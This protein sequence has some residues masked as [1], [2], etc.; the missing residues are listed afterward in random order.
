MAKPT[1]LWTLSRESGTK[2]YLNKYQPYSA[3]NIGFSSQRS[4]ANLEGAGLIYN[5]QSQIYSEMKN[6]V[7]NSGAFTISFWATFDNL[8]SSEETVL[9]V[10][11]TTS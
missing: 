8:E 10:M 9:W 6:N 7:T 11:L 4:P 2:D 5:E 3:R 1:A